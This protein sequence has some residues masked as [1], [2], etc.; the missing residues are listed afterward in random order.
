MATDSS[1]ST[2]CVA[3]PL[4]GTVGRDQFGMSRFEF[5]SRSSSRS[6]SRSEIVGCGFDVIAPIV[7]AD[8]DANPLDFLLNV[9][10][11]HFFGY[12]SSPHS[13]TT[14]T[15][16]PVAELGIRQSIFIGVSPVLR[17]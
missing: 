7:R 5:L 8:F 4:R 6:Y 11:G 3:H 12:C 10:V 2:G 14:V 1:S 15:F 17:N 16:L 9:G 13:G